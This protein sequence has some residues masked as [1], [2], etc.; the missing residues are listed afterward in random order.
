VCIFKFSL[1]LLMKSVVGVIGLQN[2]HKFGPSQRG[3]RKNFSS[4]A[5]ARHG[6]PPINLFVIPT[7]V[8]SADITGCKRKFS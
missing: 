7:L 6:G 2:L 8:L 3:P 5:I 1:E 4:L